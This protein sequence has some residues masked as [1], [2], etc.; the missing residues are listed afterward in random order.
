[1]NNPINIAKSPT[2][3]FNHSISLIDIIIVNNKNDEM[4]TVNQDLGYSDHL[5]QLFYTNLDGWLTVHL[6]ITLV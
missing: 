2:R 4:I 1:M 3:I 6:S 5:A